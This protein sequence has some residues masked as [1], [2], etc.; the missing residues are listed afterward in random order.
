MLFP[1]THNLLI[2]MATYAGL[3]SALCEILDHRKKKEEYN[4]SKLSDLI[5]GRRISLPP[6]PCAM[7]DGIA[8][9]HPDLFVHITICQFYCC[10]MITLCQF[11]CCTMLGFVVFP[12]LCQELPSTCGL[13]VNIC[14]VSPYLSYQVTTGPC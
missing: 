4:C 2:L 14:F 10:T 12:Y 5:G 8:V 7:A 11:Y 13:C 3:P 9:C 1:T 6:F